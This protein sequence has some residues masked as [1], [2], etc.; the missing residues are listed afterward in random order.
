ME[1]MAKHG[2]VGL[3]A[4]RAGID[5]KTA[6]KYVKAA[7]LPSEMV[8][9]RTWRTRSDP[10]AE[11]WDGLAARLEQEPG[12]EAKTL[13]EALCEE[14]PGRYAPGQLRTLQRRVH[15]WR[16][17]TGPAREV[18][19]TQAHRPGEA[20]QVD[21]TEVISLRITIAGELLGHLL[22]V[23][24]LP[25]SNWQ[26]ATVCLSE[27]L[28]ALRRGIQGA[29]FQLGGVPVHCQ[30][31]NSTAA[32]H[33]IPGGE[34]ARVE[35]Q[36]RPFN[37]EYLALVR[38]FGMTPRTTEIGA[39]E[40][41]G[42]VEASHRAL[43]ARLEQALLLRGH[44]DFESRD[45]W[46]SFVHGVL[47]K[48]NAARGARVQE[49]LATLRPLT[50]ARLPE[51]VEI[52]ARVNAGSTIRV[53]HCAY[54]VPSRLIGEVVR[55]H[56]HEDRIEVRFAG[57]IQLACERLRGDRRHRID[58]RHVIWSLVRKPGAFARYVY[59]EEMFPSVTFRR[60]YD[61]IVGDEPGVRAD[62][63]YLRILHLAASTLESDV[64]AAL[65]LLLAE[66]HAVTVDAVKA[67]TAGAA[68]PEVPDLEPEPVDLA[69]YDDLLVGVSA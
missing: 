1:E 48:A 50:A 65:E 53:H 41:N 27:S 19:F 13:F 26:W 11:V 33:R 31:D 58:Y 35:G 38:H 43:K 10:F 55:V 57:E 34:A 21:F 12:L 52:A 54:S 40:Q 4:I 59:R 29:L 51:F 39:K 3:A 16:G 23:F 9:P 49:E 42:D 6:R 18:M 15:Q 25:F 60:A 45:A 63:E 7:K 46:Q 2:K 5:R 24:T 62:L 64:Q 47:R 56:L 22:C 20:C 36:R 30:T 8:A 37:A 28:A 14:H 68:K 66:E 61:A 17:R 44:R 67:I 32:T 69:S